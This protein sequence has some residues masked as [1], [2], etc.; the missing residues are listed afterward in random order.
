MLG[1]DS[2]VDGDALTCRPGD[3]PS[4]GTLTLNAN[5][6]FT[7][8]PDANYNGADSFTYKANDGTADSNVATV[9]LTIN[10]VNDAPVAADISGAV[11]AQ[12]PAT[13]V[14]ASYTDPDVGDTHTFG[15]DTVTDGTKGKV[16]S[17]GNGTF[18]YDPNG[19]FAGLKAGATATDTFRYTVTDGSN[20]SSTAKVTIT[21]TGQNSVILARSDSDQVTEG[22]GTTSGNVISGIELD[23]SSSKRGVL[24]ADDQGSGPDIIR[25]ISHDGA[26]YTLNAAK[27]AVSVSGSPAGAWTFNK[28]TGDLTITTDLGGKLKINLDGATP[29]AYVYTAPTR[30]AHSEGHWGLPAADA[31][32]GYGDSL[33]TWLG[34]F[35]SGTTLTA[36]N[37]NG[38]VAAFGKKDVSFTLNGLAYKY[39]GIGVDASGARDSET[40][41]VSATKAEHIEA[42]FATPLTKATVGV[43]ALFGGSIRLTTLLIPSSSPGKPTM[44]PAL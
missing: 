37:A 44:R 28:T 14:T 10:P 41:F 35:G 33:S 34:R 16:T 40:D 2:D 8:T 1:N 27:T 18:T 15:M 5:G 6:S 12:G 29:G 3:R 22:D 38:G 24:Q 7:Y 9:S 25:S 17:N 20:V 11:F 13:T 31:Q 43:A 4:H 32:M 19:A 21:I 39:G 36:Y 42:T 23:S 30:V 26:T